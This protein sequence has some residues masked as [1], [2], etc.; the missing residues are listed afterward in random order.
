MVTKN[1]EGKS[2]CSRKSVWTSTAK[3]L[4][5]AGA[6]SR[7]WQQRQSKKA[8]GPPAGAVCYI[9][10]EPLGSVQAHLCSAEH[11]GLSLTFLFFAAVKTQTN[12]LQNIQLSNKIACSFRQTTPKVDPGHSAPPS[13]PLS[14]PQPLGPIGVMV[15]GREILRKYI[16]KNNFWWLFIASF[17]LKGPIQ[18]P[19][20]HQL[21]WFLGVLMKCL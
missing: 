7:G 4:W 11:T 2:R 14:P 3:Q 10:G 15:L 1:S 19:L 12:C 9:R 16:L 21:I 20:Y 8:T 18:C 13:P 17:I 6:L 5:A